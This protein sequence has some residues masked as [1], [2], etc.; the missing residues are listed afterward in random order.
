[1]SWQ[2]EESLLLAGASREH[3]WGRLDTLAPSLTAWV[4]SP[5]LA[6]SH[7]LP[8]SVPPFSFFA[9]WVRVLPTP[10]MG[11]FVKRD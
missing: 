4:Q 10:L 9:V 6:L 1:M 11:F 5:M 7:L 8:F 2:G 3:P